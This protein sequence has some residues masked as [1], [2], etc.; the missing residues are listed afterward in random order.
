MTIDREVLALLAS[1]L[2]A[3]ITAAGGGIVALVQLYGKLREIGADAAASRAQVENSHRTN[4]RVDLDELGGD[5]RGLRDELRGALAGIRAEAAAEHAAL[6]EATTG[7]RCP[8][9]RIPIIDP[10]PKETP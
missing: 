10:R 8:T 5:V 4:L 6:W 9:G 1:V 3:V 2:V 7:R